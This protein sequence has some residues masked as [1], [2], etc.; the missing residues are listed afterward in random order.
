LLNEDTTMNATLNNLMKF[1]R[2]EATW[3]EVEGFSFEDAQRVAEAGCDLIAAERYADAETLFAG[4]VAMNPKDPAAQLALGITLEQLDRRDEALVHYDAALEEDPKNVGALTR[5]GML[6]LRRGDRAGLAD[7]SQA[8]LCD[9]KGETQAG[10]KAQGMV[11][12]LA[13]SAAANG[14]VASAN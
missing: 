1:V 5:R 14:S 13:L 11:R 9:P 8:V 10:R 7:L 2:G 3:A 12:A 4:L 6:R